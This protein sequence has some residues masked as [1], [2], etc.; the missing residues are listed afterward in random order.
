MNHRH[1]N[2][3]SLFFW[4]KILH[5]NNISKQPSIT[6]LDVSC[7]KEAVLT[8]AFTVIPVLIYLLLK[9]YYVTLLEWQITETKKSVQ[10]TIQYQKDTWKQTLEE[11]KEPIQ[12]IACTHKIESLNQASICT[13]IWVNVLIPFHQTRMFFTLEWKY[14]LSLFHSI[15]ISYINSCTMFKSNKAVKRTDISPRQSFNAK[16][17]YSADKSMW[18]LNVLCDLDLWGMDTDHFNENNIR[19]KLNRNLSV[20][21]RTLF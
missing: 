17:S 15:L 12:I 8:V 14:I 4:D 1:N 19:T 7:R 18:P 2:R 20:I 10:I 5:S 21:V 13:Y 9:V 11:K 6:H 16:V 3:P